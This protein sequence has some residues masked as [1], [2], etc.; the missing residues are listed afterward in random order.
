MA[1][2][3]ASDMFN[4]LMLSRLQHD[5]EHYLNAGARNKKR[6]WARDEAEQIQKMRE[7]Y[8]AVPQKPEWIS[9][10]DIERYEA[11]MLPLQVEVKRATGASNG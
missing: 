8:A 1:E 10:V 9:L 11:A 4:Y 3:N 6:L 7:L 2:T 5:C